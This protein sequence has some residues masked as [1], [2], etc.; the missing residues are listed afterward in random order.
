MQDDIA[1]LQ[2]TLLIRLKLSGPQLSLTVHYNNVVNFL[3]VS[4]PKCNRDSNSLQPVGMRPISKSFYIKQKLS[5][6]QYMI[7]N[8]HCMANKNH[9]TLYFVFL[10]LD[11]KEFIS[12][13]HV[14]IS[15][16]MLLM[17]KFNYILGYIRIYFGKSINAAK[18]STPLNECCRQT[19]SITSKC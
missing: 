7:S 18:N 13:Q 8:L 17:V 10:L 12:M 9:Q 14:A 2:L 6:F 4:N 11:K 16:F 3:R 15:Q 1:Q 5:S 19:N